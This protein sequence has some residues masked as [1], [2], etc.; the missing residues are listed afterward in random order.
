IQKLK[1]T[2]LLSAQLLR[3]KGLE[4]KL[5][6]EEEKV[7]DLATNLGKCQS[8]MLELSTMEELEKKFDN[9]K[10]ARNELMKAS[11]AASA[12]IPIKGT[13]FTI[14]LGLLVSISINIS[15]KVLDADYIGVNYL[16]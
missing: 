14:L 6:K 4:D 9:I 2:T 8:T 16:C 13:I 15:R 12:N 7:S 5:A 1:E 10:K 11:E 3:I